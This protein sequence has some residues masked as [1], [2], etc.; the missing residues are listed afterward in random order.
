MIVLGI[1]TSCDETAA[2]VVQSKN[3]KIKILSNILYSQFKEHKDYGGVVPEI[4]FREHVKLIDKIILKALVRA[5]KKFKDLDA[6]AATGGPGLHGGLL[7]G[8]TIGKSLSLSINKP[9]IPINH[10]EGH[11]LSPI[12]EYDL[13]FPYL[14]LLVT[15]G[16]TMM[17]IAHKV[18]KYEILGMTLDDALGEAFDKVAKLLNIGFPGGPQIEKLALKGTPSIELAKPLINSNDCNFSF[19]GLKTSVLRILDSKKNKSKKFKSNMCSSFQ[20]TILSIIKKKSELGL[21]IFKKKFPNKKKN[22]VIVG[23]VASNNFLRKNL[24]EFA[25]INNF[26]LFVPMKSLCTDNAAMIAL[27]ALKKFNK[28]NKNNFTFQPLPNWHI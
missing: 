6:I 23:G 7:I 21:K 15:G 2:S 9:F 12:I 24:E 17:I 14:T 10:L 1:E 11:I 26:D 5:K 13:K 18:G 25:N 27:V 28:K 8:T 3:N 19:S 22:F 16:H 20:H 4:A